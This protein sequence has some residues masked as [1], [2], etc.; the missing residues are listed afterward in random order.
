MRHLKCALLAG[1]A[2]GLGLAVTT[3]ASARVTQFE[4]T[5][6]ADAF[7]GKTFGDAGAYEKI[8]G[9][10]RFAIDPRS[11]RGQRIVGLA[12]APVNGDGEVE[13]SAEVTILAPKAGG[14]G[15]M[16]YEVPNRGRTL[17]LGLLNRSASAGNTFN[18]DDPGDGFLM[19][20]GHTLVWSGW[21]TGLGDA[22]IDMELPVIE[23][24]RGTAR[25]EYVFDSDEAVTVAP[26]TYPAANPSAAPTVTVRAK[27]EDERQT[28]EGLSARFTDAGHVEI[29]RPQGFDAGAIYEV[30]YEATGDMPTGLAFV[31]TADVVS[32]LRGNGGHDADVPI[33]GIDHVVGMGISQSGR[34]MR[35]LVY[36][37]F[38]ADA[39]GARVFDGVMPH[40]AGSRKTYTNYAFAQP[41][42]YSR[43]HEDHDVQGDQ[44][45]FAYPVTT[46]PVSGETDG[47][48]K[49]CGETDTCPKVIHTDTSTEFWQ[50]RAALVGTMPSGEAIDQ[51]DDVR[52]YFLAG[53]PH[54]NFWGGSSGATKTCVY[55]SNPVS[56]APTMRALTEAMVAWVADGTAPPASV[57]PVAD[58]LVAPDAVT[59]PV[60]DGERPAPEPNLLKVRDHST[61]PPTAGADY[62]A[63]VPVVDADGMPEGGVRQPVIAAPTG[64]YYG[65]NLR[66]EG[67]A[68]GALCGLTGSFIAFPE[69]ASNAD[70]RVPLG[71]RYADAAAYEAALEEAAD[72]LVA[73][74]LMRG[75][76]IGWSV[77]AAPA[78]GAAD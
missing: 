58:Q 34:F 22:L 72:G 59:W 28:P 5:S 60:M 21:Q 43:Q 29:T 53:A 64:S 70:S 56:V 76:D 61:V 62:P 26:L 14:S 36:Q 18:A 69:S 11:P 42:R 66:K 41:G 23:G 44:F 46:D 24:S 57:Y 37:G 67:F 4:I 48:L 38:N 74:G 16:F 15:T 71:E 55:P 6:R 50:A 10:A 13:F 8:V 17:A 49:V 51:P 35:D 54:F 52:L 7:D 1:A 20:A 19:E 73:A 77:E 63:L 12:E 2:V 27:A 45:P 78:L 68:P 9:I 25:D 32:F 3:P 47:V 65:W 39:G 31:A 33:G 30:I 75:A 40:I